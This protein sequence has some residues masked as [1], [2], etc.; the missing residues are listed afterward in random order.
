VRD[1]PVGAV[2]RAA[3]GWSEANGFEPLSVGMEMTAPPAGAAAVSG[4][5]AM[6]FESDAMVPGTVSDEDAVA[7]V[8]ERARRRIATDVETRSSSSWPAL[9]PS[10]WSGAEAPLEDA[11]L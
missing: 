9:R 3:V 4:G 10:P 5:R 11:Q 2:L 1:L 7:Q 8:I 6:R